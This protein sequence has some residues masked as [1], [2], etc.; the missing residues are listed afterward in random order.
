MNGKL[1][2]KTRLHYYRRKNLQSLLRLSLVIFICCR[3]LSAQETEDVIKINTDLVLFDVT[4]TDSKGK[5]VRGLQ[6]DDFRIFENGVER[7]VEFFEKVQ[8][9]NGSRPLAIVFALDISGSVTIEELKQIRD[10][11]RSFVDGLKDKDASFAILT[12]GM[13]VNL[14]QDFTKNQRQLEKAY[15]KLLRETNGLSTHTYDAVDYAVRLLKRKIPAVKGDLPVKKSIVVVTDGFPVGDIVSPKTVIE[16]ANEADISIYSVITPSFS[17]LQGNKKPL[18]TP[19]DVSGLVE[20][21]GGKIFTPRI[22][23]MNRFFNHWLR[24]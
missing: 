19:L 2:V 12:F 18:P 4:V 15:Q 9:A 23:I 22:K 17:R 10:A 14:L 3:F 6:A 1:A 21:T 11:L 8:K 20:K 13:K 16:R 7:P 5:P 24:K